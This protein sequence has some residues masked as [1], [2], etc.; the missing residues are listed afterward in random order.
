[1]LPSCQNKQHAHLI[2]AP[3]HGSQLPPAAI[4]VLMFS[5][6]PVFCMPRGARIWVLSFGTNLLVCLWIRNAIDLH[7]LRKLKVTVQQGLLYIFHTSLYSR[8]LISK[9]W[10]LLYCW[11]HWSKVSIRKASMLMF[12]PRQQHLLSWFTLPDERYH[13][14]MKTKQ[15]QPHIDVRALSPFRATLLNLLWACLLCSC[16]NG[17]SRA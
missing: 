7:L 3:H 17:P 9:N 14:S 2:L 11:N 12:S 8:I 4:W 6:Q 10:L 1:M 13:C 16:A 5:L 15:M